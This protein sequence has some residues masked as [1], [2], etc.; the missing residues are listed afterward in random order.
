MEFIGK[1]TK[2]DFLGIRKIPII[3]SSLLVLGSVI[4][5]FIFKL[6]L[7]LDFTGGTLV[8]LNY[9]NP[10]D[11]G[12]LRQQLAAGGIDDAVVQHFGTSKDV[13]VHIPVHS[14]VSSAQLSEKLTTI[15][16][17]AVGEKFVEGKPGQ[18]QRCIVD[19]KT[20]KIDSC[21][22]QMRRVEF[23]GP[24]VGDELTNKGGLALIITL[25]AVFVYVTFRFIS[26]KFAA[27]AI[28]A[29]IH[30]VMITFGFFSVLHIEF[31]LSA[32]AAIL[33][34]L[35]YSLNDT[36]VVFDRIRENYR[37]MRKG[38]S[39]V[40]VMNSAINQTLSRTLITSGTTLITVIALFLFGGEIIHS[41]SIALL[42]GIVVG[43]YSSIYVATPIVL[44][45]GIQREDL[46]PVKKEGAGR[47]D[48]TY[49]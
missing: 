20:K 44:Q 13:L 23:V 19:A 29:I 36:I 34:V 22:V 46:M 12:V 28:I 17:D 26:W 5:L 4:A 48:Q 7:G 15:L 47:P 32:L 1:E 40:E 42:V 27:G 39:D 6:N 10:V 24:Q 43:T 25:A 11:T 8:E 41:F 33:A 31:S 14:D 16:R 21:T 35:G 49:P 38:H 18:D 37:R 2:F 3:L 30:D 45:L 9:K